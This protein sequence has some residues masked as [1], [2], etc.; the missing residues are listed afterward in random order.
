MSVDTGE[1][2]VGGRWQAQTVGAAP[3]PLLQLLG[4]MTTIGARSGLQLTYRKG[5][6]V[7]AYL[8]VEQGRSHRRSELAALLWPTLTEGGALTNL[9]QVLC[10]LR[11]KLEPV[12][13]KGQLLIDREW[14]SLRVDAERPVSDLERIEA[15]AMAPLPSGALGNYSWLLECGDLLDGWGA[16]AGGELAF[17]LSTIRQWYQQQW[18]RALDRVRTAAQQIGDWRLA[19]ECVR[20]QIRVDPWDEALHRQRM[21]LYSA[22]GEAQLALA[23]YESLEMVLRRELGVGPQ[24]ETAEL[25]WAIRDKEGVGAG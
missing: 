22:M 23:S 8:L 2:N 12:L 4:P 25:A 6:V 18:R 11:R 21:R 24:R 19:L 17:W 15:L 7:L 3:V 20:C 14:V 16:D 10:D 13:G 5:W 9:R 1:W